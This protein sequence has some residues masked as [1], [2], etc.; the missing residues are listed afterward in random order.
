MKMAE[1]GAGIGRGPSGRDEELSGTELVELC[2][3]F[4]S[5]FRII[6]GGGMVLGAMGRRGIHEALYISAQRRS[7]L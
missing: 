5:L 4:L 7:R 3:N 1:A 2:L 6:A